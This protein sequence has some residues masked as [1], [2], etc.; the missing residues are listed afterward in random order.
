MSRPI[1][2]V[3]FE[4]RLGRLAVGVTSSEIGCR[5]LRVRGVT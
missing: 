3:V 2:E 5:F 1:F 4:G